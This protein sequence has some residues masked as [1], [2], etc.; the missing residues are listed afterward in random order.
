[1]DICITNLIHLWNEKLQILYYLADKCYLDWLTL[2]RHRKWRWYILLEAL[3]C[4]V[5]F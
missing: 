1:M 2:H 3:K 4:A 5:N